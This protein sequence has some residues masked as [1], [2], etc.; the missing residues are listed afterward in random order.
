MREVTVG[1]HS[2]LSIGIRDNPETIKFETKPVN[3]EGN[4]DVR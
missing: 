2:N 4:N 1:R 3:Q